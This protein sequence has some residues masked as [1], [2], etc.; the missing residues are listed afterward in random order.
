MYERPQI[1]IISTKKGGDELDICGDPMQFDD[2]TA[3]CGFGSAF[4]VM[5]GGYL[6]CATDQ[7]FCMPPTVFN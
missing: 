6:G 1:I 3:Y 4:C 5:V 7:G 2:C